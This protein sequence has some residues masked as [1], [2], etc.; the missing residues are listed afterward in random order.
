MT[1]EPIT[2]TALDEAREAYR[3][4][5][6]RQALYDAGEVVMAD[7]LVNLHGE[8]HR[9]RRRLE[10]RLFR[11]D[12]F[13]AYQEH[14][15]PS[16]IEATLKPHVADGRAELV[17]LSHQL[18]MNLAALTAG[19][20][21]PLQTPEET[22]HLYSYLMSFIE[23]ATLAHHTGDV[24]AKRAEV[25]ANLERFD[26]EFLA[27]STATRR[28]LLAQVE[29]GELDAQ[30]LPK[31]I[32][33][34]L[35]QGGEELDLSREVI[36][37]EVAFYLLAGAHTSATAFTRTLDHLFAWRR[38]H[39]EDA[40]RIREDRLLL[41]RCVHETIRLFPSSP[42]AMRWALAPVNLRSTGRLIPEGTKVVIDLMA[43]NRDTE[44]WGPTAA[45]FDPHRDVP[46]GV[47]PWGLSFGGGM[48]IC[49]GQDLAGG[50]LPKGGEADHDEHLYGLVAVAVQAMIDRGADADPDEAPTMDTTTKRPYWGRYPVVFAA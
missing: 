30:E 47:A 8:A 27:P 50:V 3:S 26:E 7:V 9:G 23:G 17:T 12:V 4:K 28:A 31:D 16:V 6:L 14:L 48:H 11:R 15:F 13:M 1:D 19:V 38:D 2:I 49:I 18:M 35:L 37:R 21:R 40:E 24:D 29:A 25:A 41:Q 44:V 46:A 39:P 10:N 43:I 36:R 20:D 32:L 42:V 45:H 34:V 33:T 22:F 5:D